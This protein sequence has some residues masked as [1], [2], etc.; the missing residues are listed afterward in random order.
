[1]MTN[2]LEKKL[3][4]TADQKDKIYVINLDAAKKNDVLREKVKGQSAEKGTFK[5]EKKS[6]EQERDSKIEALLTAEQKPKYEEM[7]E[8]AKNRMKDRMKNRKTN[9]KNDSEE[10]DN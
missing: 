9:R 1:M 7:K 5:E 4:L 6:I 3:A 2:H 8:N 10:D